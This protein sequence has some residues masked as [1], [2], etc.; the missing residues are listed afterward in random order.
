MREVRP[1]NAIKAAEAGTAEKESESNEKDD[2]GGWRR[3]VCN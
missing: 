3:G 2:K 1:E